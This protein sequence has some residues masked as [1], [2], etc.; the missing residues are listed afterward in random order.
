MHW[1]GTKLDNIINLN[2]FTLPN[3]V[4]APVHSLDCAGA[5]SLFALAAHRVH[6]EASN[7]GGG[8]TDTTPRSV[9]L[10]PTSKP[11]QPAELRKKMIL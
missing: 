6:T 2:L 10:S 7:A 8:E 4:P 9:A 3:F 11:H 5:A 1:G